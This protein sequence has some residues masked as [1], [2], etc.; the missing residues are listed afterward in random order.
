VF[1][2]DVLNKVSPEPQINLKQ[3]IHL[4]YSFSVL[5]F[6]LLPKLFPVVQSVLIG[7]NLDEWLL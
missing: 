1:E 2:Q 7:L 5:C 6:N 3:K 4:A